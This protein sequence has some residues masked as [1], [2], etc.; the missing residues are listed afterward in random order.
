MEFE[1]NDLDIKP[2]THKQLAAMYGTTGRTLNTWMDAFREELGE[3]YGHYYT[4]KQVK[5]ILN[6]RNI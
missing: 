4:I 5:I 6:Y 3:R 2:Y 1:N